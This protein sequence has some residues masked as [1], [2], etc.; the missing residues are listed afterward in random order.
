MSLVDRVNCT[1]TSSLHYLL[2][3]LSLPGTEAKS[4]SA[5]TTAIDV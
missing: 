4:S 3:L 1:G 2:K 5:F